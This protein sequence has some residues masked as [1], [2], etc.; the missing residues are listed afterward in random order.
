MA[1]P[2]PLHD[3]T[4]PEPHSS[5]PG[6]PAR[7]GRGCYALLV[8]PALLPALVVLDRLGI[9]VG[10]WLNDVFANLES[11]PPH[12][13]ALAL[14][15]KGG[16]SL[17][18]ALAWTRVLRA[19]YPR[20]EVPYRLVLAG[21]Q[22][23]LAL[24][25]VAPAKAGTLASFGILRL[26]IRGSRLPTLMSTF[27]VNSIAFTIFALVN[28]LVVFALFRN[29]IIEHLSGPIRPIGDFLSY[30]PILVP[31]FGIAV[32]IAAAWL[33]RSGRSKAGDIGDQL[34]AGG[35]ILRAPRRYVLLV[36][37]P[38]LG[39]YAC[40]LGYTAVFMAAFDIPVTL[41]TVVLMLGAALVASLL[42]VTP[43]GIGVSQAVDV[44]IMSAY[45][46]ADVIASASL[47]QDMLVKAWNILFG[48]ILAATVFGW[49]GA[50]AL[51]RRRNALAQTT[52]HAD[53]EPRSALGMTAESSRGG[54][55][56][57]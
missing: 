42:A 17:F 4:Q 41:E 26:H 37:L 11:V 15:L 43:G 9:D 51:F 48:L 3:P 57:V 20:Q 50:M 34:A 12:Y 13:V 30:Y 53:V 36:F 25:A 21:Y 18:T 46:P 7:H 38:A 23:G 1:I 33:V 6:E 49:Q 24:N 19:A 10:S 14:L 54:N 5:Q 29:M 45:A 28:V 40:R 8:L 56:R 16:E 52:D 44:A 27:A 47:T 2:G 32:I 39:A 31:V 35:A 55:T 22:G